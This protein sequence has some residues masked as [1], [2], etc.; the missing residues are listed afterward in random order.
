ML[1][2]EPLEASTTKQLEDALRELVDALMRH[3]RRCAKSRAGRLAEIR[4]IS[5]SALEATPSEVLDAREWVSDP[6]E[7]AL[8]DANEAWDELA[9]AGIRSERVLG[10]PGAPGG[11]HL[12]VSAD[13]T[14]TAQ[15][16]TL[17]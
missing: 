8:K 13:P 12:K 4:A 11:G 14:E 3:R 15:A 17:S 6:I 5:A 7:Y 1:I 10:V 2:S 16:A 9:R